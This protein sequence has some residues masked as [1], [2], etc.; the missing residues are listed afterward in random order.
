MDIDEIELLYEISTRAGPD[1]IV[2]SKD[3]EDFQRICLTAMER[4]DR[5]E[6][7]RSV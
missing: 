2:A 6:P 3:V 7:L 5:G 4:R 1:G